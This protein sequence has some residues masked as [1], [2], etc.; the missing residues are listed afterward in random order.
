V[1]DV[2]LDDTYVTIH[3]YRIS[4]TFIFHM[5]VIMLTN[6]KENSRMFFNSN[7]YIDVVIFNLIKTV[8]YL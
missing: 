5:Y 3:C 2:G 7:L 4:T 6:A 1:L 8:F